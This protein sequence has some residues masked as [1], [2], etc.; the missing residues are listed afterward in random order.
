MSDELNANETEV[1]SQ[2]NTDGDDA[3]S[4]GDAGE[5]A[6][7]DGLAEDLRGNEAF[8]DMES[9]DAMARGYLELS[10]TVKG[11]PV[12]PENADGYEVPKVEGLPYDDEALGEFRKLAFE[13]GMTADQVKTLVDWHNRQSLAALEKRDQ[14]IVDTG[15]KAAELLQGDWGDDFKQ[16]LELS[17]RA[18]KSVGDGELVE[19][20]DV[21]GL[22]NDVRLIKLFHRI[23]TVMREDAFVRPEEAPLE[24]KRT[25]G[26][27]PML[28]FESMDK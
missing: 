20:L 16:N 6:F 24:M 12:V 2:N 9:L 4:N 22:G 1:T 23:G 7:I 26:G 10:E 25:D 21:T 11:I 19:W 14:A 15:K 3:V 13:A 27:M 28:H 8:K 17:K 18:L 5:Q